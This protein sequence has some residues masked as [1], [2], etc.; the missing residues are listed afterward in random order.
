MKPGPV[1][2]AHKSIW[3]GRLVVEVAGAGVVPTRA[4][5]QRP[6]G[7]L[8]RRDT[9]SGARHRRA[10]RC[11]MRTIGGEGMP[12]PVRPYASLVR[13]LDHKALAWFF[14]RR[15]S[16]EGNQRKCS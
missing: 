10:G 16:I 11:S 3:L 9:R 13:D 8:E 5:D 1:V 12:R 7:Q 2:I 4:L 15:N 14:G 6:F